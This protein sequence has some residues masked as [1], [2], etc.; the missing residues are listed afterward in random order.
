[1]SFERYANGVATIARAVA[2]PLAFVV[3]ALAG[4]QLQAAQLVRELIALAS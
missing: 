3:A 2:W 1:L 4:G